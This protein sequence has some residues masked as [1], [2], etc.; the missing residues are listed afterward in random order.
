MARI[1]G[2][3][4]PRDKRLDIA[5]RYIYGIGPTSAFKIAFGLENGPRGTACSRAARVRSCRRGSR[6][7]SPRAGGTPRLGLRCPSL[8]VAASPHMTTQR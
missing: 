7:P 3:D 5:L 1:A 2:V 6:R 8:I 4:L